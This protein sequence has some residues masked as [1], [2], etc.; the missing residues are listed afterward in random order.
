MKLLLDTHAFLWLINDDYAYLRGKA[1]VDLFLGNDALPYL[2]LAS[3]WEMAIKI[4]VGKFDLQQPL[5]DFIPQQLY[6]PQSG[7]TQSGS[8]SGRVENRLSPA[9][10]HQTVHALLTH[11]AFRCSSHQGMRCFPASLCRNLV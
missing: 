2:S 1:A 4:R 6:N 7:S 10:P 9:L 5:A 11:T 8:Q 3:V